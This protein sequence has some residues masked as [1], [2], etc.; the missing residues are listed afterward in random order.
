MD[1]VLRILLFQNLQTDLEMTV[2]PD[3]L[4]DAA[5][6]FLRRQ[7]QMD[8]KAPADAGDRDQFSDQ[9]RIFLLEFRKFIRHDQQMCHR[10][11]TVVL[12]T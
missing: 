1:D 7:K 3:L 9:L 12:R 6:G 2:R 5:A 11:K 10:F 8:A 4:V